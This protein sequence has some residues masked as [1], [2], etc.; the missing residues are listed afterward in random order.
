L[1]LAV[2]VIPSSVGASV[3]TLHHRQ[4]IQQRSLHR[5]AGTVTFFSNHPRQARTSI[6][7]REVRKAHVWI[8][9]LRRELAETLAALRPRPHVLSSPSWL[10]GAFMCIH[11]YEGAWDAATGNGYY[12]GLQ[13]GWNEWQRFGGRYASSANLATPAEQ[14]A[15]GIAYWRV[16]GFNP[17]PNTAR[18]CGL[19]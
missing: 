3:S 11:R 5:W 16:A 13:F 14:I 12:G 4:H 9:V 6:G 7:R 18:A 2:V 15:A 8:R 19:L 1:T 10:W 17:W